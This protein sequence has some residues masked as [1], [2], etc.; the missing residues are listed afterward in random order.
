VEDPRE[1]LG[2]EVLHTRG[3]FIGVHHLQTADE[4]LEKLVQIILDFSF[5]PQ[6][7]AGTAEEP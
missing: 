4:M 1:F 5:R 7:G 3:F 6:P 2:A